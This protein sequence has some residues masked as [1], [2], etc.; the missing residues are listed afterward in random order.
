MVLYFSEPE[1]AHM[2]RRESAG[3]RGTGASV[4]LRRSGA[5]IFRRCM[6]NAPAIVAPTYAW[7]IPRVVQN[8]IERTALNGSRD[9]YFVLTCGENI[10]GA[11][12]T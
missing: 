5:V 6:R 9:V 4:F 7:R 10:C 8:W 12:S 1:T 3:R 2:R 11:G